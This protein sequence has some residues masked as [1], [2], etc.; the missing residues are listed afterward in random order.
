MMNIDF[1]LVQ[2][3]DWHWGPFSASSK[4]TI[5]VWLKGILRTD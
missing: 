5:G 2:V 3:I 1:P 4:R